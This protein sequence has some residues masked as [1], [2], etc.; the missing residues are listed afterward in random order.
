VRAYRYNKLVAKTDPDEAGNTLGYN[1]ETRSRVLDTMPF[2]TSLDFDMEVWHWEDCP[3]AYSVATHWYGFDE[4]ESNRTPDP[5]SASMLIKPM[6]DVTSP[7]VRGKRKPARP[8]GKVPGAIEFEDLE[9]LG[10]GEGVK[11]LQRSVAAL[12]WS[13]GMQMRAEGR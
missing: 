3:T 8:V 1:V 12:R 11:V 4:T 9:M 6:P 5:A 7:N 2:G 10:H 13:G